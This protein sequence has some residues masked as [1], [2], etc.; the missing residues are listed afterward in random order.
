METARPCTHAAHHLALGVRAHECV[1]N[2]LCY[3]K[4]DHTDV[5]VALGPLRM[6]LA[7]VYYGAGFYAEAAVLFTTEALVLCQHYHG[8]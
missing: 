2:I 8:P 5:C 3:Y 7:A 1:L 6:Q 4:P